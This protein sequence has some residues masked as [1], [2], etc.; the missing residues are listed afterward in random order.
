MAYAAQ[1]VDDA[2]QDEVL[3][4]SGAR[5]SPVRTA[6]YG[7]RMLDARIEAGIHL[8]FHFLPAARVEGGMAGYRVTPNPALGRD[9]LRLA[10]QEPKPLLRLCRLGVGLHAYADSW[11]HAGF[12][13]WQ[14]KGNDVA[15]IEVQRDGRWRRLGLTELGLD[16]LPCMGHFQ[17]G[18]LPD[19]PFQVWRYQRPLD[20]AG[21][22]RDN[23]ALY[24]EAADAMYARLCDATNGRLGDWPGV[25][26]RIK[27]LLPLGGADRNARCRLWIEAFPRLF[28]E[29]EQQY[30]PR[31]WR[32]QAL[33][34]AQSDPGAEE[35]DQPLVRRWEWNEDPAESPWV[36]FHHAALTHQ[37]L[38]QR[39]IFFA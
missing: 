3:N 22:T 30:D 11:S 19:Q 37:G 16:L 28:A 36:N 18:L 29:P 27:E 32:G 2:G 15:G 12:S 5:F 6:H 7:L 13:A 4:V 1:Y 14:E 17:A 26:A 39:M 38:A 31:R 25:R 34:P 23:P 33:R 8:P 21:V 9:L 20:G 35:D 10:A 24:L